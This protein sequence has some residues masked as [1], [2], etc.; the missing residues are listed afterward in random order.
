MHF[1]QTYTHRV[2]RQ[3]SSYVSSRVYVC[4]YV[5]T[6]VCVDYLRLRFCRTMPP[7]YQSQEWT[8]MVRRATETT[9]VVQKVD[10]LPSI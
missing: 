9:A 4:V 7:L 3:K 8:I 5:C 2:H 10:E 1:M 6:C